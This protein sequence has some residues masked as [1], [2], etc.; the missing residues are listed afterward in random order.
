MAILRHSHRQQIE[1]G[2]QL[3][4]RSIVRASCCGMM[5]LLTGSASAQD[6]PSTWRDPETR[7]IYLK[8]GDSLSL[9]YRRDGSPIAQASRRS[10]QEPR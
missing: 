3:P 8:V 4:G 5:L 9:R 10:P 7:C 1:A 6:N 2:V